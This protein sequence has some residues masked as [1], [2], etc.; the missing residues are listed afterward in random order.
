MK[1][2]DGKVA[3]I[4]GA[5][6]G[7]GRELALELVRAKASVVLGDVDEKGL[8]ETAALVAEAGGVARI[9]TCDVSKPEQVDELAAR[10]YEQFGAVHLLFN[11]AGVGVLGPTWT[12]TLED[13]QWVLGINV[14]GVVHGIRAFVPRM[15]QQGGPAHVINTASV[16]GLVS[17]P[18]NSVYAVSK[19]SVVALSECLYH[20]LKVAGT[21]IGVSVLCPAYVNTGIGDSA[22][23]RPQELSATNPHAADYEPMLRKALASGRLSAADVAKITVEAVRNDRFYVL[24][25]PKIKSSIESRM[26]DIL[27]ERNPTNLLPT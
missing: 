12:T 26:R 5:A 25:H 23:N 1:E 16:A 27:D 2:I 10:S 19:H 14:M 9:V 6:S 15:I 17:I 8:A 18:G 20:D 13:W 4:T 7:I 3:V 22:R 24:P 11:N 21:S